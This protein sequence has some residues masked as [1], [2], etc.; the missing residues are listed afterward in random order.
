MKL[1]KYKVQRFMPLIPY[2]GLFIVAICQTYNI[3]RLKDVNKAMGLLFK[4]LLVMYFIVG[5]LYS[6]IIHPNISNE[7]NLKLTYFLVITISYFLHLIMGYVLL[8]IQ[9]REIRSILTDDEYIKYR[10]H[11]ITKDFYEN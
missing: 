3:A 6:F 7:D 5:I 2:L 4:S 1:I 11:F 9:S 10:I 8:Y